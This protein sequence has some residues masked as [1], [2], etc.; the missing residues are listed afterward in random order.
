MERKQ[1]WND[2]VSSKFVDSGD[3]ASSP[4]P[5]EP[6]ARIGIIGGLGEMGTLFSRFFSDQGYEVTVADLGTPV[7]G[8]ELAA[9]SDILLFS[10]PLHKSEEIIRELV[11]LTRPD[12]LVMDL[13][14]LKVNAVREM[15]QSPASVVGLHPKIGRAS[16]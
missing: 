12:Q 5:W 6:P 3:D 15:L 16:L 10:V 7:T 9:S 11:P 8:R 13:T 4:F 1:H 2:R 14:S